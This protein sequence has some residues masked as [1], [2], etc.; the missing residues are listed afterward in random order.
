MATASVAKSPQTREKKAMDAIVEILA[1]VK[2][3]VEELQT[4]VLRVTREI[5]CRILALEKADVQTQERI[6]ALSA[7]L[8]KATEL[9]STNRAAIS[10]HNVTMATIT[11]SLRSL[12]EKVNQDSTEIK[13]LSKSVSSLVPWVKIA[14]IIGSGA[15]SI[16]IAIIIAIL[17]GHLQLVPTP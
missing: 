5:E 8:I 15:F 11:S 14:S 6:A 9:S 17:T 7:Q 1:S 4:T 10:D 2:K 16:L 3:D 12:T 13:D